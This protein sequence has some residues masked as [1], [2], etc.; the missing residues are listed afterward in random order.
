MKRVGV[1]TFFLLLTQSV[2]SAPQYHLVYGS[3]AEQEVAASQA[4]RYSRQ[5]NVDFEVLRSLLTTGVVTWRVTRGPYAEYGAA[6]SA[7][8]AL[9]AE[10]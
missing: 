9:D 7:R 8:T 1:L 2:H 4:L 10:S 6:E 5:F 3:F